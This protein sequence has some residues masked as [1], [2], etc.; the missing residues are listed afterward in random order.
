MNVLGNVTAGK[1]STL[2]QTRVTALLVIAYKLVELSERFVNEICVRS[3]TRRRAGK[4]LFNT[5]T[6]EKQMLTSVALQ[7]GMAV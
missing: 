6:T 4:S 3:I 5:Q 7:F 1:S 2:Q